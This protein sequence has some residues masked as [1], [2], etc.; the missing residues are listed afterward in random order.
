MMARMDSPPVQEK[1]S[2]TTLRELAAL[3]TKLGFTAFGGPAAHVA[4]MED[5]VVVRRG[6]IHHQHFL[7]L[8]AAVNFIPGPNSTELAIHIG[9][10][11]AG[12]RGL[13][14]AGACFITPAVLIIL[15]IAWAYVKWGTLPQ[16][17]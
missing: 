15:P 2:A 7:D 5:E 12:F 13:L 9:Q 16:A 1:T 14:V 10:L 3:F 11:R 17:Q 8:V 4:L 6:W